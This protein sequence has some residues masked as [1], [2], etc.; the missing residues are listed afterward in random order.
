M[1]INSFLT[2]WITSLYHKLMNNT[3]ENVRVVITILAVGW[4]VFYSF[5]TPGRKNDKKLTMTVIEI[6]QK[7][8]FK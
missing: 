7:D 3:V 2:F 8:L 1:E 5:G 4:E 6:V